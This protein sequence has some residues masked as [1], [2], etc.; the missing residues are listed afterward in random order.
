[1]PKEESIKSAWKLGIN[2]LQQEWWKIQIHAQYPGKF[3][4]ASKAPIFQMRLDENLLQKLLHF[5]EAP[6]NIQ[7]YAFGA[8]L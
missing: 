4:E 7:H 3:E 6:G 8:Q 1:M 5:L 2:I